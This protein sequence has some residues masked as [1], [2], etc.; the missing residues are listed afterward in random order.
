[1]TMTTDLQMQQS[2][3]NVPAPKRHELLVRWGE[4]EA[5]TVCRERQNRAADNNQRHLVFKPRSTA[6]DP[7]QLNFTCRLHRKRLQSTDESLYGAFNFQAKAH[8]IEF[9]TTISKI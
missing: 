1:M 2:F 9:Q 3:D 4:V 7:T 6:L 5:A 8:A